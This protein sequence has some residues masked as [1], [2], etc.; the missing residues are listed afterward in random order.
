MFK[1]LYTPVNENENQWILGTVFPKAKRVISYNP[2]K[3]HFKRKASETILTFIMSYC[4]RRNQSMNFKS[5]K[6][7]ILDGRK[8]L[9][10]T[11]CRPFD[12]AMK[13]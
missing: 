11:D 3:T 9:N 1:Q 12:I 13:M 2:L 10:T 5:G 4:E 8:Q 6:F 7:G